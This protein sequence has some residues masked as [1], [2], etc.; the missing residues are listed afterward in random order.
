VV[1]PARNINWADDAAG[2]GNSFSERLLGSGS[3]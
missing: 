3:E 2:S 1:E